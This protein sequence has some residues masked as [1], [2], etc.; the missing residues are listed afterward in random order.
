MKKGYH[1][2]DNS[3]YFAHNILTT[4]D[5]HQLFQILLL[6]KTT[7]DFCT[8]SQ[9]ILK[10][11]LWLVYNFKKDTFDNQFFCPS[12]EKFDVEGGGVAKGGGGGE[13]SEQREQSYK[14]LQIW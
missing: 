7:C 9:E 13:E 10:S 11:N 1:F 14:A 3:Y 12:G 8:G 4:T 6:S 5:Y 2:I